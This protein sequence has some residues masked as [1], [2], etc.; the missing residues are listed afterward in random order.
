MHLL[1]LTCL[2]KSEFEIH[3][4]TC[5]MLP[6]VVEN[7]ASTACPSQVRPR[8]TLHRAS[9]PPSCPR[10]ERTPRMK[11]LNI[12]TL[13]SRTTNES[14]QPISNQRWVTTATVPAAAV[15]L[16]AA[17][18][19]AG[20]VVRV[21]VGLV[22]D[23]LACGACSSTRSSRAVVKSQHLLRDFTLIIIVINVR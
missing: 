17:R 19:P 3:R 14:A 21:L 15:A 5:S 12:V 23:A 7:F 18:W 13:F 6:R 20:V 1:A 11:P 10:A 2:P 9:T 16:A 8:G 4:L 22:L